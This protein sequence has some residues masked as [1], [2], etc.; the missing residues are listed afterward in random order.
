MKIKQN[1]QYLSLGIFNYNVDAFALFHKD[2][3]FTTLANN[4]NGLLHAIEKYLAEIFIPFLKG[5]TN[6]WGQLDSQVSYVILK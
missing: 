2:V 1:S 4:G 3:I 5:N 6:G